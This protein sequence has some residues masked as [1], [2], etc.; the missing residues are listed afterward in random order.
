MFFELFGTNLVRGV[1]FQ[2]QKP[3]EA[4][5]DKSRASGQP[6]LFPVVIFEKQKTAGGRRRQV[7]NF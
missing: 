2:K 3:P 1:I 6:Q 4:A 7:P 5:G